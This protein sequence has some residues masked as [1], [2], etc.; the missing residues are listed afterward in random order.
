MTVNKVFSGIIASV[1]L[2]SCGGGESTEKKEKGKNEI[3]IHIASEP[4]RL[5]PLTAESATS[6]IVDNIFQKLITFDYKTYEVKPWLAKKKGKVTQNTDGSIDIAWEIKEEAKWMDGSPIT[7][8]DVETSLKIVLN[9]H[10]DCAPF[11]PYY[12][13]YDNITI[14]SAN[15]KKFVIH[16]KLY[17]L[18]ENNIGELSIMNAKVFD[19]KALL[20]KF[21]LADFSNAKAMEN[22][23]QLKEQGDFFNKN[24]NKSLPADAG[25]GPYQFEKWETFQSVSLVRKKSWWADKIADPDSV[26][27]AKPEKL[28]F[29][30]I[31]DPNTAVVALKGREIDVMGGVPTRDF[32]EDMQ[33]DEEFKKKFHLFTPTAF[34]FSYIGL[35]MKNKKLQDIKVRKA[36]SHLIDIDKIIDVV[37]Y[38]LATRVNSFIHPSDVLN[39]DKELPLKKYD[40]ELAKK[41][42]NEAGWKDSNSDGVLDKMMDGKRVDMELTL[43]FPNGAIKAEKICKYYLESAKRAGVKLVL[44]AK[45]ALVLH[46]EMDKHNFEMYIG[47][48]GSSSPAE[49]DPK[50]IW[51]SSAYVVG[52]SN[53]VGFG[54]AASDAVIEKLRTTV[55]AEE[56]AVYYKELQKMVDAEVPYI[57]LMADKRKIAI[58]K[59]WTNVYP[60]GVT[61]GYNVGEFTLAE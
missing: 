25:S 45:D 57:F 31:N 10:A 50:Q 30:V 54:S 35:N 28:I 60:S 1:L 42:L 29:K 24:F 47:G 4:S 17:H 19:P 36:L 34:S 8:Y 11:R 7:G 20:K 12:E 33:K 2:V 15:P 23:P 46:E 21:S 32:V 56:R 16:S 3:R 52:G 43:Y 27:I 37:C 49:T 26:F 55:K 48:W 18:A 39:Y 59:R 38:G 41:L 40:L 22:D 14:D 6:E 13:T 51:H 53:Y 58:S 61:P 44:M 5:N 9:P